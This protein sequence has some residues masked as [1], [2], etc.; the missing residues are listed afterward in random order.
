VR[1]TYQLAEEDDCKLKK[2]RRDV[3]PCNGLLCHNTLEIVQLLLVLLL[4]L[5][6][7]LTLGTNDP[8]GGLKN[9]WK[10]T[11]IGTKNQSVQS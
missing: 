10:N 4:L 11:K 6:F 8:E 3:R 7:F 9:Y 2:E 1:G 5:L